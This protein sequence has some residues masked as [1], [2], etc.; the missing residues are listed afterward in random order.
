MDVIGVGDADVDI[1]LDVDRIPG[2]DE[3]LL[4]KRVN[5]Y[6][7]GMIANFLVVLRRLGTTCGFHGPV[8]DDEYGALTLADLQA[9]QVDVSG[10]VIKPGGKTYFCVVMLDE[11]GEKSLVVAPTDCLSLLPEDFSESALER[12]RHVHTIAA[13]LPTTRKVVSYAKRRGMTTSLDLE[14]NMVRYVDE[15][16]PVLADVDLLFIN[17]Q[18]ARALGGSDDLE[19]AAAQ[20]LSLGPSVVCVTMG[21]AGSLTVT[22]A[23]SFHTEAF[24]V[25]VVDSTGAGD[26]FAAGFVHGYLKKWPLPQTAQFASAVGALAVT[27]RGGHTGAPTFDEVAAFLHARGIPPPS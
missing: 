5:L 11:S 17:Q 3:K 7:G 16:L 6:P 18:A 8:G 10:A 23:T 15:L 25:Q 24:P 22:P 20:I 27:Y 13:I 9:N 2:R 12:A 14:A 19:E 1:Y 4:A 26:S 21:A